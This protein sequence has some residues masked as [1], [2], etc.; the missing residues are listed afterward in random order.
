M[1]KEVLIIHPLGQTVAF[2]FGLFNLIT[3][4]TRRCFILSLHIN[5]GVLTYA[6][7]LFGA[8]VGA[9]VA[10]LASDGCLEL[11][12]YDHGMYDALSIC[13]ILSGALSGFMLLRRT[14]TFAWL[15]VVHRWS[16]IAVLALFFF[17]A[18][19]GLRALA[20]IA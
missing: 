10:G 4:L 3:G 18:Y 9:I 17:Q 5:F 8:G 19:S 2:A 14:K 7:M 1:L 6:L 13:A 12:C 20:A 11:S 16:N 15:P